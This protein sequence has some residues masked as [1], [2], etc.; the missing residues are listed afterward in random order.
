[1]HRTSAQEPATEPADI[2]AARGPVST[3]RAVRTSAE[4]VGANPIGGSKPRIK[5]VT[6]PGELTPAGASFTPP[7]PAPLPDRGAGLHLSLSVLAAITA[8]V[9][10]ALLAQKL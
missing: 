1:M 8:L 2:P 6:A 3:P 9:F 5:L 4:F 10:L 7:T